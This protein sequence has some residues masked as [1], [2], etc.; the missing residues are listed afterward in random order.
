MTVS[1][2]QTLR[3][4]SLVGPAVS[5]LSECY[6]GAFHHSAALSFLRVLQSQW[7]TQSPVLLIN[8]V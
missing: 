2:Q 1:P 6:L 8:I 4:G 5:V 7:F 3:Q